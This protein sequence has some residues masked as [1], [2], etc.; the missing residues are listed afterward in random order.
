M[1]IGGDED[2]H[3]YTKL[4]HPFAFLCYFFACMYVLRFD[5][6]FIK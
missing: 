6:S 4:L 3:K 1:I 5:C 2:I